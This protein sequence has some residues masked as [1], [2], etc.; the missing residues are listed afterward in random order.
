[1]KKEQNKSK[2]MAESRN[3]RGLGPFV[4]AALFTVVST[5]SRAQDG[6][7]HGRDHRLNYRQVNLVSDQ[8]GVAL[9]QDT[10]LVNAWGMSFSPASPFWISAN[11]TGRST[12]YAVTNDAFGAPQVAKQAL[13]VTIPG[14]GSPTGQ[15][16]NN[17][18]NFNGDLFLFVS[19]D[20]VISGWRGALGTE[21]EVLATRSTAIYKGVTLASAAGEPVLL[22]A[23]FAEGTVDVYDGGANLVGQL[24]DPHAPPG[25]APFNVQNLDGLVFVTFAKQDANKV[26]DVAGQGHGLIDVL[27]LSSGTFH[28]FAAGSDAGGRL[29]EFNSPWGV[30]IAP[31]Q[32]GNR[33]DKLLVGNFGSGTIMT[34]DEH[35]HFEGLLASQ[36]GRP[37]VIEG[38]WAIGFGSGGRAGVPGTLYFTAG[39]DDESHGLFGSLE[40]VRRHAGEDDREDHHGRR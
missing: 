30:A 2:A 38:L 9:V 25:Y 37:V 31:D 35:G 32:F 28:R 6:Y 4:L 21:A 1:M 3:L 36:P 40:P 16:F 22:A 23:N 19:E 27:D 12:L 39:P 34:F 13:E 24:A 20:G 11:G 17:T 15:V 33:A 5:T 8:P 14:E 7:N 18:T 10:N 26:D 29:R